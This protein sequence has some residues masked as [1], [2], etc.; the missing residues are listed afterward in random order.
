VTNTDH[1]PVAQR[2]PT[3]LKTPTGRTTPS[4]SVTR[5]LRSKDGNLATLLVLRTLPTRRTT[6]KPRN[7]T[8]VSF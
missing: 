3:T 6:R 8:F 7:R 5:F 2:S 1:Q 4:D